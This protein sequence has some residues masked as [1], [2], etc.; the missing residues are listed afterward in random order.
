M[1]RSKAGSG[2]T[3]YT[4]D[5]HQIHTRYTPA[6]YT[7]PDTHQIHTSYTTATHQ[8]N[9]R[10]TPDAHQIHTSYTPAT[11]QINTRYTPD[12]HQIP[13]A[14]TLLRVCVCMCVRACVC[15]CVCA[16][17]RVCLCLCATEC[18]WVISCVIDGRLCGRSS[19][20]GPRGP[21]G[22]WERRA[23]G[24][25]ALGR[26]AV[27]EPTARLRVHSPPAARPTCFHSLPM[28][29]DN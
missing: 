19:L 18:N 14:Q 28:Y 5:T 4:P 23:A 13:F 7:R 22:P 8:I 27:C 16:C 2:H 17:V 12:A 10:Y 9:T 6:R 24:R 1:F 26:A 15:V 25:P 21:A 29:L 20:G 3:E 11:H